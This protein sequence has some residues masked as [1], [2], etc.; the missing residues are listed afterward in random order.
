[1]ICTQS[2]VTPTNL[3]SLEL[4]FVSDVPDLHLLVG[5]VDERLEQLLVTALQSLV[6][7]TTFRFPCSCTDNIIMSLWCSCRN[8]KCIDFHC[9]TV[10]NLSVGPIWIFSI[11][12]R[13]MYVEHP[14]LKIVVC[15]CWRDCLRIMWQWGVYGCSAVSFSQ[16]DILINKFLNLTQVNLVS[17]SCDLL[18][19][20]K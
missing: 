3:Q 8:M 20:K 18:W 2:L 15:F 14:Y 5:V 11:Y 9:S 7:L 6:N 19:S 10:T 1:M 13:W 12:W 4:P 16:H 17:F